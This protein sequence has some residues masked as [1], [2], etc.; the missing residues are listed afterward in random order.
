VTTGG[1]TV[2]VPSWVKTKANKAINSIPGVSGVEVTEGALTTT[3]KQRECCGP[4]IKH[5]KCADG[6]VSLSANLGE[7]E[8]Y[9]GSFERELRTENWGVRVE[10][11]AHVF[12]HGNISATATVGDYKN[13][14][15]SGCLYGSVSMTASP[16]VTAEVGAEGCVVLWGLEYCACAG[17]S[18]DATISFTGSVRFNQCGNCD[19]WDGEIKL[20]SIILSGS[21]NV[22]GYDKDYEYTIYEDP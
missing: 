14:C 22:L 6:E 9:G 2:E 5:E 4:P 18:G 21:F 7:I 15:D 10:L 1:W 8:I 11:T 20:N 3:A 16:G 13:E 12:V 17:A 19:G